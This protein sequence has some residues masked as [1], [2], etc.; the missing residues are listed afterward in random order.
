[1]C[2]KGTSMQPVLHKCSLD[3]WSWA[4]GGRLQEGGAF[5]R[6]WYTVGIFTMLGPW[7]S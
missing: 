5:L 2:L 4:E 1:M 3:C 7:Q 6:E